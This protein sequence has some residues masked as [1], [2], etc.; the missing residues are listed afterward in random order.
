VAVLA[1][2]SPVTAIAIR[3]QLRRQRRHLAVITAV[4][5]LAGLLAVHHS[6]ALMD[7]HEHSGMGAV[8]QMCLGVFTAVGAALLAGAVAVV[9]LGRRCPT[10]GLLRGGAIRPLDAPLTRARHGPAAVCVLCVSRR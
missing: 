10:R 4:L 5:A 6:G 2:V 3:R 1:S 9:A 8:I 7:M